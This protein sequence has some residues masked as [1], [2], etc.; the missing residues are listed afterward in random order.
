MSIFVKMYYERVTSAVSY[1]CTSMK[2][3]MDISKVE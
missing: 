2:I 1:A 3:V